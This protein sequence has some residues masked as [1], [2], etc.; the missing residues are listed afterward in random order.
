MAKTPAKK[1][2]NGTAVAVLDESMFEA[3]AGL[4]LEHVTAEDLALPF[5]KVLSRQDPI[6]DDLETAKVGDIYNTVTGQ[7]YP[8]KEGVLVIPCA[9]QKRF[10]QWAPRGGGSGAPVGIFGPSEK[11][12]TTERSTDDNKDYVVGGEGDYIEQTAQH[13]VLLLSKEGS[14]RALIAMKST[15]L[16]KSRKWM[17]MVLSR[18]M[19]G[20][21]GVPFTPPM[22]SHVYRLTTVGQENAKGSWHGWEIALEGQVKDINLYHAA[23]TFGESV[24]SG[25]VQVKHQQDA[26]AETSLDDSVPF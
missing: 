4:G 19:Q 16:K 10:I 23:K 24:D 2:G 5:L 1:N 17:S 20:V 12:P 26:G 15:Q 8:G 13:Y 11:R 25:Q 3:D 6:L 18:Q 22:F 9:F 14:E 7:A 21:K